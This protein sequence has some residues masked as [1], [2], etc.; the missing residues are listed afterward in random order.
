VRATHRGSISIDHGVSPGV[1]PQ[2]LFT[3]VTSLAWS[4]KGIVTCPSPT[5]SLMISVISPRT[6]S[7][8]LSVVIGLVMY[9][10]CECGI[11]VCGV[12]V[13]SYINRFYSCTRGV[14]KYIDVYIHDEVAK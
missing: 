10:W 11:R 9:V 2:I 7:S 3:G 5:E 12:G 14:K 8:S 4:H 13:C 6:R 1:F